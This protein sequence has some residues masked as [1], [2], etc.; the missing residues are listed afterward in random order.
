MYERARKMT[1]RVNVFFLRG[2]LQ[3]ISL[4][5]IAKKSSFLSTSC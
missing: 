2:P 4:E 5:N 3:K 1:S